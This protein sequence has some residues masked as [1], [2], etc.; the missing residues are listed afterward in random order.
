M[1]VVIAGIPSL[2]RR[3]DP[4]LELER[5]LRRAVVVYREL[6]SMCQILRAAGISDSVV[7]FRQTYCL[8]IGALDLRLKKEVGSQALGRIGIEPVQPVAND[9]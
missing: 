7:A 4:A 3:V 6:L 8:S 9:E 2:A 5:Q 1:H